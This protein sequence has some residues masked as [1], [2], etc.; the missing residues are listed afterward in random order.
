M[1]ITVLNQMFLIFSLM[2]L[3]YFLKKIKVLS[4]TSDKL[5][6]SFVLK[7]T[8]TATIIGSAMKNNNLDRMSV[9]SVTVVAAAIF[10][11]LP[12]LS[13]GAAK[14]CRMKDPVWSMMMQYSN[15]GFMGLPII[16]SV[17]GEECTFYAAV[18]MMVFN[19]HAFSIGVIQIQGKVGSLK[20]LLKKLCSPMIISAIIAFLLVLFPI[21]FPDAIVNTTSTLGAVTTPV[22]MLVIGS[23]LAEERILDCVKNW[24]LYLMCFFKLLV[25]PAIVYGVLCLILG[26]D[27][28]IT[29]VS[30]IE[31]GLP[32]ASTVSM[33]CTE[34]GKDTALSAQGTCISTILSIATIPLMLLVVA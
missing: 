27:D 19:L 21:P 6:I 29:K 14:L 20:P 16:S 25:F 33:L 10:A 5:F 26:P 23:Q 7:V 30:T 18:F 2:G 12:F 9:L 28:I 31:I 4:T 13:W 3:G 15:L 24:K 1:D 32:V 8:L 11:A 22:A 34:Y 17:F